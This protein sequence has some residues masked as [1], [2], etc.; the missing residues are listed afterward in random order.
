MLFFLVLTFH[1][2]VEEGPDNPKLR[3]EV[4]SLL[5]HVWPKLLYL[6]LLN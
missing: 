6:E 5:C 2:M 1:F 4:A 3:G